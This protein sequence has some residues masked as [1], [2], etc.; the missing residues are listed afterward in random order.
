LLFFL[1]LI[2][3][4]YHTFFLCLI[5]IS[6][7]Q[8]EEIFIFKHYLLSFSSFISSIIYPMIF[9]FDHYMLHTYKTYYLIYILISKSYISRRLRFFS[10]FET[11]V[12]IIIII[13]N[14]HNKTNADSIDFSSIND[15][16]IS[17]YFNNLFML[18]KEIF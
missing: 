13:N 9:L 3:L 14:N 6:N 17:S 10:S 5:Y 4:Y 16:C 18:Q 12:I 11:L 7:N 1:H 15:I 8:R 2:C